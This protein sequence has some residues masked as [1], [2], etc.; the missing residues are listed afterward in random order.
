MEKETNIIKEKKFNFYIAKG[1]SF[2]KR[3]ISSLIFIDVVLRMNMPNNSFDNSFD[4]NLK[5]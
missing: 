5:F 3:W 4:S 2:V 1:D